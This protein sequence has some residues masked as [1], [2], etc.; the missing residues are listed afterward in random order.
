[1]S[2]RSRAKA[3][4]GQ[5]W[6]TKREGSALWHID[7][8]IQ[9]HRCRRSTGTADR[10]AA[11]AFAMQ[12]QA[13]LY[14]EIVLGETAA[15]HMSIEAAAAR[16]YAEV[17]RGTRYGQQAQR[18]QLAAMVAILGG[19]ARLADLSDA[20]V[21]QLVQVLR[22]RRI[23]PHN[24]GPENQGAPPRPC[25][26]PSTV[27]RYVTTLSALCAHARKMWGVEV[28]NWSL[29]SHKQAEPRGRE[30]FLEHAQARA[31]W[32]AAVAH[33]RPILLLELTTGLRKGNVH[34]LRWEEVSLP[35]A[36]LVLIQKGGRPLGVDLV[37]AA[38]ALLEGLQP[39]ET[40]RRGPVFWF[41][42]PAVACRCSACLSPSKRGHGIGST[43]RSFATAAKEAGLGGLGLRFHDLRHSFASW[44]LNQTGDLE[45]VRQALG[46]RNIQTTVRY[47]HLAPGRKAAA[48]ADATAGLLLGGPNSTTTRRA[49]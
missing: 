8:T 2:G 29:S 24:A 14:R 9:G 3:V 46:H 7:I 5:E 38:V 21:N 45:L 42:N 32:D 1:M 30:V 49:S 47:A 20:M 25:L 34:A 16:W 19:K 17:G 37:P 22:Q 39:D 6:L 31:L 12:E 35:M 48:V 15:Q 43:R 33:L 28:G 23:V 44:L 36:R 41:G 4:P 11:G 40:R 10:A 26:S 13:R 18:H 27:N